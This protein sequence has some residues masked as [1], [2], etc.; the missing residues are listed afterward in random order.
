MMLY[1]PTVTIP[2]MAQL[3]TLRSHL[4]ALIGIGYVDYVEANVMEGPITDGITH[5][6]FVP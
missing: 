4:M 6:R 5:R 1:V 2:L 3:Q